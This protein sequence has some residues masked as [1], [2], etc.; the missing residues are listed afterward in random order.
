MLTNV[1]S[2]VNSIASSM[3]KIGT[4]TWSDMQSLWS[5]KNYHS[6]DRENQQLHNSHN[7]SDVVSC[8]FLFL[9]E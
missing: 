2:S 3:G 1:Q 7:H 8:M 6:E 9:V 4:K 5:G